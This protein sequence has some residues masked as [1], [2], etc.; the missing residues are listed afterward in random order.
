MNNKE[1]VAVAVPM[2]ALLMVA[3]GLYMGY[4]A[5]QLYIVE[6]QEQLKLHDAPGEHFWPSAYVTVSVNGE[7]VS[8]GWNVV[9]N[10]GKNE[11]RNHLAN[12]TWK[13]AGTEYPFKWI[14]I[15]NYSTQP[16]ADATNTTLAEEFAR[17][18]GTFAWVPS[19]YNYTLS[20]TWTAGTFDGE[21]INEAGVFDAAS[22]GI[23]LNIQ[24]WSGTTLNSGDSLQVT[25]E[26]QIS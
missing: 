10:L 7:V 8:E 19:D 11:T 25:F 2:I 20:Y 26:Y 24:T 15:G 6:L 5:G 18:V 9:C 13:D 16:V 12:Q 22:T 4:A 23:M 3:A 21:T 17:A 1:K 14:A